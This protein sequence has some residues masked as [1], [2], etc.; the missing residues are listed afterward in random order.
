MFFKYFWILANL[1]V[2]GLSLSA[3]Q[4]IENFK[5]LYNNSVLSDPIKHSRKVDDR[6]VGGFPTTIEK[7]P[8][9]VSLQHYGRHI[10]GG[11]I[12]SEKWILTAAHCAG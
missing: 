12:I 3:S 1:L 5:E 2:I 7:N 6:I 9:Q 4:P 8:W 10:C 11:S